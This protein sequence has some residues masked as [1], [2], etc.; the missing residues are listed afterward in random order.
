MHWINYVVLAVALVAFAHSVG[1]R[2]EQRKHAERL[3]KLEEYALAGHRVTSDLTNRLSKPRR[4]RPGT[5]PFADNS[6][7]ADS[8]DAEEGR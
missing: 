8:T 3:R 1:V 4:P 5:G 6:A 7:T 2:V